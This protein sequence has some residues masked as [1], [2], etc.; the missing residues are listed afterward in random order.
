[1]AKWLALSGVVLAGLLAM[2]SPATAAQRPFQC[3]G[4]LT[5]ATI[6]R[7]VVVLPGQACTLVDSIV[8]RGVRVHQ[9]AYF[10]ATNT[11]IRRD[12]IGIGAQTVFIDTGSSLDSLTAVGTAQ[13]YAFDSAIAG[14]IRIVG[15][16]D[17]VNVCGNTVRGDVTVLRSGRDILVGDPLAVDC[18]GNTVTRG[19]ILVAGNWTDVELVVSGNVVTKGNLEVFGN[20][21]PSDKVV[22]HNTSGRGKQIRCIKNGAPFVGGSNQGWKSYKGDCSV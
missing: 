16:D 15:T 10:Q 22:R 12:V 21:G 17:T 6:T 13:V 14:S 3:E 5:G 9:G 18:A 2:A 20:E 19:S 7:D 11:D 8:K 4:T 1:M